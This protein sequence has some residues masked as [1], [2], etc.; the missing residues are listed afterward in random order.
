[1]VQEIDLKATLSGCG[2]PATR[3]QVLPSASVSWAI[4]FLISVQEPSRSF[5]ESSLDAQLHTLPQGLQQT[6]Y[7]HCT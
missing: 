1:M 7:E 3:T 5:Q 4:C 2:L 6:L